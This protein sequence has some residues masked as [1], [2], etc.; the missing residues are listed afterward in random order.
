MLLDESTNHG[1]CALDAQYSTQITELQQY[2]KDE[3][4]WHL[5]KLVDHG[6]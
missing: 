6:K 1:A 4:C 2:A 5:K 3:L